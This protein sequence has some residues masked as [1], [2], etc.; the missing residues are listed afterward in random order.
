MKVISDLAGTENTIEMQQP[1]G[2]CS[3]FTDFTAYYT[4]FTN[5]ILKT[6][7]DEVTMNIQFNSKGDGELG[8]LETPAGMIIFINDEEYLQTNCTVFTKDAYQIT[9]FITFIFPNIEILQEN[10]VTITADEVYEPCELSIPGS[11]VIRAEEELADGPKCSQDHDMF[12]INY[13]ESFYCRGYACDRCGENKEGERW[14]C[15]H[16]CADICFNCHP[17]PNVK[18][19]CENGH[20]CTKYK[21]GKNPK[22][23]HG[24][25][26]YCDVCSKGPLIYNLEFF[27]CPEC[28]YDLCLTCSYLRIKNEDPSEY[29]DEVITTFVCG[30]EDVEHEE[31]VEDVDEEY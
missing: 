2:T 7:E 6:G 27:H 18:P 30:T 16:D 4:Q 8:D 14:F 28:S 13:S 15:K 31:D 24:N 29:T 10:M 3:I 9:G 17:K 19:E 23:Y 22:S 5:C 20:I 11:T 26:A 25:D 12:V 21:D 1:D